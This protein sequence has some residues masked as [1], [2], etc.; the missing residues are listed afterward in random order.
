MASVLYWIGNGLYSLLVIFALI[1]LYIKAPGN[2]MAVGLFLYI[3]LELLAVFI[4]YRF[5]DSKHKGWATAVV[6]GP[7]SIILLIYLTLKISI[8]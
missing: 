3:L 8:G 7:A 2:R 1:F 4:G 5:K 6:F